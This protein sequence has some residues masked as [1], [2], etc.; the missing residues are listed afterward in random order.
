MR[1]G[2]CEMLGRVR[3]HSNQPSKNTVL[4]RP[5]Y[6]DKRLTTIIL[7]SSLITPARATI[8]GD[9]W[10]NNLFSDLAPILALFGEQVAKQFLSD[11]SGL[12]DSVLFAM[13]PL[14]V[15]TAIVSAI[16]IAG[17]P[18]LKALVGRGKEGL[19]QAE[20][21]LM[22]SNSHD[23]GEMYNG[24]AIVRVLGTP[25]VFQFVYA[26]EGTGSRTANSQAHHTQPTTYSRLIDII[27]NTN[28]FQTFGQ[29][30]D[31]LP[32]VLEQ[33]DAAAAESQE[34]KTFVE[35]IGILNHQ[36]HFFK[37]ENIDEELEHIG[38]RERIGEEEPQRRSTETST[39]YQWNDNYDIEMSLLHPTQ[40]DQTD[41]NRTKE[42]TK[43]NNN[44]PNMSLN[45]RGKPITNLEK[46]SM[47]SIAVVIQ[48]AVL[49]FEGV[50]SYHPSV[51]G[52]FLKDGLSPSKEA[53]PC[54][55]VGTVALNFG[56]FICS[57]VIDRV[58]TEENWVLKK[59]LTK[60]DIKKCSVCWIQ[61]GG[62]VNDQVFAPYLI[63]GEKS[64]KKI[65]TSHRCDRDS[66]LVIELHFLVLLGTAIS[67]VG[68]VTQFVGLRGMNWSASIAQLGATALVTAIRSLIRRRMTREPDTIKA[69]EGYELDCMAR[70][71]THCGGWKVV[72]AGVP[73]DQKPREEEDDLCYR[74]LAVRNRL[75]A[76]SHWASDTEDLSIILCSAMEKTLNFLHRSKEIV[77]IGNAKTD[78][79]LQWH[80]PVMACE[81]P[82]VIMASQPE[83]SGAS[84]GSASQG[85][86][87]IH[88]ANL[89][90]KLSRQDRRDTWKVGEET[91]ADLASTLSLWKL[92][93][94]EEESHHRTGGIMPEKNDLSDTHP[95]VKVLSWPRHEGDRELFKIWMGSHAFDIRP[96]RYFNQS[97][98][99][100]MH[101]TVGRLGINRSSVPEDPSIVVFPAASMKRLFSQEVF[102]IYLSA[103]LCRIRD[104]LGPVECIPHE[105][106]ID[107]AEFR[108]STLSQLVEMVSE[109]GLGN[110]QEIQLSEFHLNV[111]RVYRVLLTASTVIITA[112]GERD[113]LPLGDK[114]AE[115]GIMEHIRIE[116]PLRTLAL[117]N[118]WG[119]YASEIIRLTLSEEIKGSPYI[120]RE[121]YLM[122]LMKQFWIRIL[123]TLQLDNKNDGSYNFSYERLFNT[124]FISLVPNWYRRNNTEP[125][126]THNLPNRDLNKLEH[127]CS[128]TVFSF[129]HWLTC[130][131]D[132]IENNKDGLSFAK[133]PPK[134][135]YQAIL[136][137]V[138]DDTLEY[139]LKM[140]GLAAQIMRIVPVSAIAFHDILTAAASGGH[141]HVLQVLLNHTYTRSPNWYH[142][143]QLQGT[144]IPMLFFKAL[145][146]GHPEVAR[147]LIRL[148]PKHEVADY[149][150][151]ALIHAASRGNYS[152]VKEFLTDGASINCHAAG[153]FDHSLF[154]PIPSRKKENTAEI[155]PQNISFR[156]DAEFGVQ[157]DYTG[158]VE[159]S[160]KNMY[161]QF[162]A[163]FCVQGD[164]TRLLLS[165]GGRTNW[166]QNHYEAAISDLLTNGNPREAAAAINVRTVLEAAIVGGSQDDRNL[167]NSLL[168]NHA[169]TNPEPKGRMRPSALQYAAGRGTFYLVCD[170]LEKEMDVNERA[171]GCFG[172][173]AL[174]AAA[175]GDHF[176]VLQRLLS[177]GADPN[178]PPA[179]FGGRTALQA[180]AE[181]ASM[182]EGFKSVEIL[183]DLGARV[184]D[185][186]APIFGLTAIQAAAGA[187]NLLLLN[188][189]IE[190]Y[191]NALQTLSCTPYHI[192][193][194]RKPDPAWAVN[195]APSGVS[196][197][198]ALQAASQR[199][200]LNVVNR[201]LE[202]GADVNAP[203]SE[204]LGLTA[205]QAAALGGHLTVVER[206]LEAGAEV[207]AAPAPKEGLTALQ[208]AASVGHLGIVNKLLHF[209]AP[210]FDRNGTTALERAANGGHAEV[211]DRLIAAGAISSAN[212]H[213]LRRATSTAAR[214]GHLDIMKRLVQ[215]IDNGPLRMLE[216][217]GPDIADE[218]T[219][220]LIAAAEGGCLAIV[221]HL[222]KSSTPGTQYGAAALRIA[223]AKGHW[224]VVERLLEHV[225]GALTGDHVGA[226]LKGAMSGG[227]I[228]IVA[229]LFRRY[230]SHIDEIPTDDME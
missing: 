198:T 191:T 217:D 82:E 160:P 139:E 84:Q 66:K 23:V 143:M 49:I 91:K 181:A 54:T 101:R 81:A 60:N 47:A 12:A 30:E 202:I 224:E 34:E 200:H 80:L 141:Y 121:L 183:L 103:I 17:H 131:M 59:A 122:R 22:S 220:P 195:E 27:S 9:N 177:E 13:A 187:G 78:C 123:L 132:Y 97:E 162:D 148:I 14:G 52:Q 77:W 163:E 229:E 188:T 73:E 205:L 222:L 134:L 74:T 159:I 178:A 175:G 25:S 87:A 61:K 165:G 92:R 149:R 157:G 164:Y 71:I 94:A 207:D 129:S 109:T 192:D 196:G 69:V 151:A 86:A 15:I 138:A 116:R 64:Q 106:R 26:A 179:S 89:P 213:Q 108:H 50:I 53:F 208:A 7:L 146:S 2:V 128:G 153:G 110:H 10:A 210:L 20:L 112:L 133:D 83:G 125:A 46:I 228:H 36:N 29:S 215:N 171:N 24:E 1:G 19:A 142:Q 158:I 173:T 176:D 226:A 16:R 137:R 206:L 62:T 104:I 8:G 199:G 44:P 154:L 45:A 140:E 57:Y 70:T 6:V 145:L 98:S 167:V 51:R 75:G 130:M 41:Q 118:E 85:S 225:E 21:E 32:N 197:R 135:D 204:R 114:A 95:A 230:A 31:Q 117:R 90:F 68:F 93:F 72:P 124:D 136:G 219:V 48:L 96:S 218:F 150:Q 227:H 126:V 67:V 105:N 65:R 155:P 18:W 214:S 182:Y 119:L 40:S 147:L 39:E 174:Q 180:A 100:P 58:T 184:V 223:S 144:Q 152:V 201:L 203:P 11:S 113:I 63:F 168:H 38:E 28:L 43:E 211:F 194:S 161:F 76:L 42:K 221:N 120:T 186:P 115:I 37:L 107:I 4:L 193:V 169:E 3:Q 185:R 190:A 189:L 166:F 156:L 111:A 209:R 35:K 102:S 56:M 99:I 5:Y 172:R 212:N 127:F 88:Y 216:D 33:G 55:A 170:L 79:V